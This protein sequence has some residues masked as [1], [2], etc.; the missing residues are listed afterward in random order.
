MGKVYLVMAC[1]LLV[2]AGCGGS[3]DVTRGDVVG[4]VT[5]NGEPVGEGFI[6]FIP[7][8]G[9]EGAPVKLWI[10]DGKFDSTSDEID[11]RGIPVGMN[12]VEIIGRKATGKQIK[13]MGEL[14]DEVIQ[15]IPARYNEESELQLDVPA[16]KITHNF[17]LTE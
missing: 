7:V 10:R 2:L 6:Q 5:F 17:E 16:K 14:E 15:F 4:T 1:G 11:N 3:G 8:P 12:R 13:V 9:V